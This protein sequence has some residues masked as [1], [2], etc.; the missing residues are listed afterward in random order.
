MQSAPQTGEA[1]QFVAD[2]RDIAIPDPG[3]RHLTDPAQAA[4]LLDHELASRL[5]AVLA[6]HP[7][8]PVLLLSGGVD[9]IYVAAAAVTHG[10]RP[11]AITVVTA[12]GTDKSNAVAASAALDLT[13]DVIEL[14]DQT[15]SE[16][17]REAVVRLGVPEL[18]EVSYAVPLLAATRVLDRLGSVGPILTGSAA[19]AILAGGR[20]LHHPIS[21]PEAV[22]ELD[23]IVRAESASNFRYE[24]LVPDFHDRV[25]P[26][27]S[28]R[29]VHTFQTLRFWELAETFA[30][31]ALF[32]ER[33]GQVMDKLCLRLACEALLPESAR[34]L[35][36]AKKS[37][38]QRSA[39]IM[40]ALATAA[41]RAAAALPGAQTY[42]DPMTE[43]GEAVATRL[44]LALLS[45][46]D[47]REQ[48]W[49]SA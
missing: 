14:D 32:G 24:R 10:I 27:Y 36:W 1:Q 29:F 16:L 45:D 11:H 12:D 37:P 17:A 47:Y 7:G 28:S 9:S 26:A 2:L 35:A 19:D 5:N 38:I 6:A 49:S 15:V 39:G 44:F 8:E 31:P 48:K 30:P 4:A 22:E 13:H 43:P 21:S 25:M 40:D 18:W 41:R 3:K 42:T 23:R 46:T 33:D 34:P 20:T